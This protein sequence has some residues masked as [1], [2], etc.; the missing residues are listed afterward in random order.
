M[1]KANST[2]PAKFAPEIFN[3]S[4]K[5]A[6]GNVEFDQKGDRKN[7]EMTIFKMEG[8]KVK[9]VAIVKNGQ[10]T[11]FAQYVA[12]ASGA[13]AGTTPA[14]APASAPAA[15]AKDEKKADTKPAETKK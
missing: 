3:V 12:G 8:G 1:K 14:A 10:T 15:P 11:P 9:P 7:A 5:G 6:T 13:A 2:D 4:F